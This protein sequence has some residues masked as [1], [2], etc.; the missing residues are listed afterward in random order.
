MLQVQAAGCPYTV[1]CTFSI[2]VLPSY[3]KMQILI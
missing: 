1:A 3:L 2:S